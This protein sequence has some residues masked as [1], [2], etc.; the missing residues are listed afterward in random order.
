MA[1]KIATRPSVI[2]IKDNKVLVVKSRYGDEEFYLFPGGGVEFGETLKDAAIRETLEET[3]YHVRIIKPVYINEY[4]D[5][6]DKS[7]RVLNIFFLARLLNKKRLKIKDKKIKEVK[8]VSI[9]K[10]KEI[11]LKP[12]KIKKRLEKDYKNDFKDFFYSV[13]YKK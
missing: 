13:D 2:V 5:A 10:I 4:I 3:G 8:W 11:D 12:E 7:R 6:R 9:D 1:E